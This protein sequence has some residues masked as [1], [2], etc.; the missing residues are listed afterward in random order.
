MAENALISWS[1]LTDSAGRKIN[2]YTLA[3]NKGGII[4]WMPKIYAMGVD[5]LWN[6]F[7]FAMALSATALSWI[8]NPSWLDGLDNTYKS[9]TESMFSI[10]NPIVLSVA[11]FAL[12]MLYILIDSVKSNSTR[13]EKNDINR[14]GAAFVIMIC[15]A[16]AAANPFAILKLALSVVQAGVAAI[17]GTNSTDLN[18]FSVDAMIRQPTLIITYNGAVSEKCAEVWSKTGGLADNG[19]CFDPGQNTPT[20]ITLV[21]AILALIMAVTAFFFAVIAAW[22][23]IRHLTMAVLGFVSLPWVAAMSMFRR[24]QFDQLGAVA[25]VAAGNMAMVFVV[26]VIALGGPTIVSK[27]MED[28][29]QSGSAVLQMIALI[30]TYM[31]LS[32]ILI[33]AT[34]KHSAL[35]RSLKA[36]TNSTL[37]TYMGSPGS[38]MMNLENKSLK[39]TF[40]DIRN[41]GGDIVSRVKHMSGKAA[42]MIGRKGKGV[43]DVQ[44]TIQMSNP[45]AGVADETIRTRGWASSSRHNATKNAWTLQRGDAN[46]PGFKNIEM[47]G[48]SPVNALDAAAID[49]TKGFVEEAPGVLVPSNVATSLRPLATLMADM[50][51]KTAGVGRATLLGFNVLGNTVDQHF[52]RAHDIATTHLMES[53]FIQRDTMG[54]AVD[55]ESIRDSVASLSA[56]I[57][58]SNMYGEFP[59]IGGRTPEGVIRTI[60]HDTAV[61]AI[62]N[63]INNSTTV[64]QVVTES[65]ANVK[66]SAS[67]RMAEFQR[68]RAANEAGSAAS[69]TTVSVSAIESRDV[70]TTVQ[71]SRRDAVASQS[72]IPSKTLVR[73]HGDSVGKHAPNAFLGGSATR[74]DVTVTRISLPPIC[75][76][77]EDEVVIETMVMKRRAMGKGGV[78]S[79]PEHDHSHDVRFSPD[80]PGQMVSAAVGDGFGDNIF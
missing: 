64:S 60:V 13:L 18:V 26:Q 27:I 25:A 17:A 16:V 21:L 74:G 55:V 14:I 42:E 34:G 5:F 78:A 51:N 32:G 6:V 43:D 76:R 65:G 44:K 10:V 59:R 12:L 39:Q 79:Y 71:Q 49:L 80:R 3:L 8:G 40:R 48:M 11:G 73:Y 77:A 53:K 24:R 70:Q 41:Q 38:G 15:I 50:S 20:A 7:M 57:I 46:V 37:R 45:Y 56:A 68:V 72:V 30:F 2:E 1:N 35:V 75:D 4:D 61:T 52:N 69:M 54:M 67:D 19:A 58:A 33:A 9:L 31:V 62:Q 47:D 23:Y 28:W 29:G 36:D 63:V 22:K 66:V